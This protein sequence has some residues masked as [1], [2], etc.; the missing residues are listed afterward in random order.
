MLL[1][2]LPPHGTRPH[3][4]KTHMPHAGSYRTLHSRLRNNAESVAFY[5]GVEREGLAVRAGFKD[6][7]RHHARLL[8]TQ[9]R[10]GMV[11]VS[12]HRAV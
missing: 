1:L 6:L 11:Q 9:W 12:T 5:R 3:A 10:F 2:L 8:T 7:A 4:L